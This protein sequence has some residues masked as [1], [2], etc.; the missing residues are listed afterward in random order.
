MPT[1][2]M[3]VEGQYDIKSASECKEA[4]SLLGFKWENSYSRGKGFPACYY[5][6]RKV[7]FNKHPSPDI[8]QIN[9]IY[10]ALCRTGKGKKNHL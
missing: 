9:K 4:G 10:S 2:K 1:G 7:W 6:S 5:D 8:T 3:C